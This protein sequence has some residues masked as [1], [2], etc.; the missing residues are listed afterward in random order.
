M[1]NK[2]KI[3]IL[4]AVG[5]VVLVSGC[6]TPTETTV[7]AL[8]VY[9]DYIAPI[10]GCW[11]NVEYKITPY[12]ADRDVLLTITDPNGRITNLSS[13]PNRFDDSYLGNSPAFNGGLMPGLYTFTLPYDGESLSN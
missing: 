9:P 7:G 12:D 6:E 11:A 1:M 10:S 4:I 5:I 8:N 3:I 2:S 13:N